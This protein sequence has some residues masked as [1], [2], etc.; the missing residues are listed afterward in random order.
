MRTPTLEPAR[1]WPP[2]WRG[3]DL[4]SSVNP[5]TIYH[6]WTRLTIWNSHHL[7]AIL[8]SCP[9]SWIVQTSSPFYQIQIPVL[10]PRVEP[11][12]TKKTIR[13]AQTSWD[14]QV[15]AYRSLPCFTVQSVTRKKASSHNG[16]VF[17]TSPFI[18]S[19]VH[20]T[21]L[22]LANHFYSTHISTYT[23]ES[24][25]S[26]I[27]KYEQTSNSGW[28]TTEEQ[29]LLYHTLILRWWSPHHPSVLF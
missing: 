9:I 11:K 6:L 2:N 3:D 12:W 7:W 14:M 28:K 17:S 21:P 23:T 25:Y 22:I 19:E 27:T 1:D 10:F 8:Q 16:H 4:R 18:P 24:L 15:W 5:W 29:A 20:P 26:S 13:E